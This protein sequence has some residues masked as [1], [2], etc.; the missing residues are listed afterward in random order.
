MLFLMLQ[1]NPLCP[2]WNVTFASSLCSFLRSS[3]KPNCLDRSLGVKL[4][5]VNKNG[6]TLSAKEKQI[7]VANIALNRHAL[8][9][10][11]GVSHQ[12]FPLTSRSSL[13]TVFDR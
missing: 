7:I 4:N 9:L 12:N 3:R 5:S 13:F 8:R 11:Y 10:H 1:F 2:P 6:P